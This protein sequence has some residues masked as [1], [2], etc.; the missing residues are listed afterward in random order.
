[1]SDRKPA[2]YNHRGHT[3]AVQ[4]AS[5]AT[6]IARS[7]LL[8]ACQEADF[9]EPVTKFTKDQ[10]CEGLHVSRDRVRIALSFL[11]DEGTL[12]PV[13]IKGG[14]GKAST[15]RLCI[16]NQPGRT[17]AQGDAPPVETEEEARERRF[18]ALARKHGAARALDMMADD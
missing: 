4:K 18:R 3:R 9:R 15:Y 16:A 6:G 10:L 1:M 13:N 14:R 12:H 11:R 7:V 2:D 5:K 8:W 17:V